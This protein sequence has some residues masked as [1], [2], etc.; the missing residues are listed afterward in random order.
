[1]KLN[2]VV[3]YM[4]L[5]FLF[6]PILA[7][8]AF[9]E[10]KI[11]RKNIFEF[12]KKPSLKQEKNQSIISFATKDMC[13]VTI[14]IENSD[15]KI[16]RHLA[17]GVLGSNA[18]EPFQ[19]DTL[20]QNIIWDYKDDRGRY[21]DELDTLK[22]RVSLGLQAEYEKDLY[23]SPYKRISSLPIMCAAPE[24]I[25]VYEGRGRDHLRLFGHDGKYIKTIYPFPASQIKNVIGLKWWKAPNGA[26]VLY[27]E[28]VYHQ[29]LLTS[30]ENDD[31]SKQFGRSSGVA[32]LGLA[33]MGKRIALVYEHLN[34]VAVDGSSGGL[35]LKG[36]ETC[37]HVD[38]DG[39][40]EKGLAEQIVGPSSVALSPD[41]KSIYMTGYMWNL[42]NSH[43]P[44]SLMGVLK[45][46][47]EVNEKPIIFVGKKSSLEFGDDNFHFALPTS[48]DTD[49]AGNVYVSDFGNN[50]IQ[51]FD[52]S[53][54][55]LKSI[56]TKYPAKVA[57]H[58]K[59]GEIYVFSWGVIGVCSQLDKKIGAPGKI[60]QG[61]SIFSPFPELQ[62]KHEFSYSFGPASNNTYEVLM[63]QTYQLTLDSWAE[64][65]TFW[66]AGRKI[67]PT[68]YDVARGGGALLSSDL[69]EGGAKK[70]VLKDGNWVTE[71]QVNE[72][73]KKDIIRITPPHYNI[74]E[75]FFNPKS[76]KLYVGEPDSGPTGKAWCELIE[77][78]PQSLA[79]KIIKLPFNPNDMDFDIE[80]NVYL[81]STNVIARYNINTWKEIPFDYGAE[82]QSV[83]RDGGIGGIASPVISALMLPSGSPPCYHQSG[84]NVNVNGDIIVACAHEPKSGNAAKYIVPEYPGRHVD[85][86]SIC[87]HIFDKFGKIKSENVV[88]GAP[89]CDGI[90]IDKNNNIYMLATPTRLIEGKFI[91]DGMSATMMK[92]SNKNNGRF[93]SSRLDVPLILP[94][95]QYP[96]RHQEV[97]DMWIENYEWLYGGCG[98]AG[99]NDFR[100]GGGCACWFVRFK[101][102]YF[103]RSFVPEPMQYSIAVLDSAGNLILKIGQYGNED[104]KGKNSKEPL[105]GDEVG[106]FHP[107][108]I[109]VHTDRRLFISDI[110]NENIMS[111][112]LK[113]AV[114][115][116]LPLKK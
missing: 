61:I 56:N 86:I 82:R 111:V 91:D 18:P 99:F 85:P 58:Q 21:I 38:K 55:F 102:D 39:F 65:P 40:D 70:V 107:C 11:K 62:K 101:L 100:G 90:A 54:A 22:I 96:T 80:G 25:Y 93:L 59:T 27:K 31:K 113:Y 44:N 106:L 60:P 109:A 47:Y 10:F 52:S 12:S 33:V 13:D 72:A 14:A 88:K 68:K 5:F 95:A 34:R 94:K 28:S 23:Y 9:Q 48:V 4:I 50:R 7:Q 74:Q 46:N 116:I 83:G 30:G 6:K 79:T 78:D 114:D 64:L 105:G 87:V 89:Q 75:L 16:V 73:A 92:F 115:E 42:R 84:I 1:M 63:G 71:Y 2:F 29:T 97:K 45:M 3:P 49:K 15:G 81:R 43:N 24:G 32:A 35:P 69:W 67:I 37:I 66:V 57:V 98:F 51:I 104:S 26:D 17:S 77:I 110:G 76:E 8:D 41:G 53:G 36:E 20:E 19:K 108:F 112:K 103:A